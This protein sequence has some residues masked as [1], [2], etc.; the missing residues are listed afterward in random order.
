VQT[1]FSVVQGPLSA[2][3]VQV[4]GLAGAVAKGEPVKSHEVH[5]QLVAQL[6][7]RRPESA[8]PQT[9]SG[10]MSPSFGQAMFD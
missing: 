5:V 3:V 8:R 1:S 4:V 9:R 6:Q 7:A 2:W 10:H